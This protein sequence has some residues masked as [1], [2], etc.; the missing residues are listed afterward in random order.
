MHKNDDCK[1]SLP[2]I[3]ILTTRKITSK[4]QNTYFFMHY[5]FFFI[6]NLNSLIINST[7][8]KSIPFHFNFHESIKKDILFGKLGNTKPNYGLFLC[9]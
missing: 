6:L 4:K 3:A 1:M 9:N 7:F 2:S 5:I 8:I